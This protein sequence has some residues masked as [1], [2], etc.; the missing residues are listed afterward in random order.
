M[1]H[2][3]VFVNKSQM[4]MSNETFEKWN[5]QKIGECKKNHRKLKEKKNRND[6]QI[7]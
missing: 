2:V 4:L 6:S 5:F 7:I 1:E 3:K